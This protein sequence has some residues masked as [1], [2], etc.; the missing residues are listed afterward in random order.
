MFSADDP[1]FLSD[2][3]SRFVLAEAGCS[4]VLSSILADSGDYQVQ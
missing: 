4:F 1:I 3:R 2:K